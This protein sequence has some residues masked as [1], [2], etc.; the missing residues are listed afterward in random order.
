MAKSSLSSVFYP[1]C[2]ALHFKLA[3]MLK[4]VIYVT[5]THVL[6]SR[7]LTDIVGGCTKAFFFSFVRK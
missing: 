3:M 6:L 2:R 1:L 5:H 4:V 7:D